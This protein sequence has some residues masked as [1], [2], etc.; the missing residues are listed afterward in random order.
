MAGAPGAPFAFIRNALDGYS[1]TNTLGEW[2]KNQGDF[3]GDIIA[4]LEAYFATRSATVRSFVSLP[5]S[6][7]ENRELKLGV[8]NIHS[9]RAGMLNARQLSEQFAPLIIPFQ[10][11]L[12]Q[13]LDL[14]D[15]AATSDATNAPSEPVQNLAKLLK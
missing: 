11:I 8:L 6:R 3:S 4:E 9:D 2:C 5:V 7:F 15:R 14:L 13:L 1:D 10:A 12:V